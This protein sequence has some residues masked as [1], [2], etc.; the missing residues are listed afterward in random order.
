M[1]GELFMKGW[2]IIA[3]SLLYDEEVSSMVL[4]SAVQV[5]TTWLSGLEMSL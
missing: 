4:R 2:L 3:G 1:N 5:R